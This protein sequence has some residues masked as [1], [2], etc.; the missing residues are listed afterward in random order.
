M[1]D[2]LDAKGI[3]IFRAEP[4]TDEFGMAT[5]DLPISAEPNLGV[6]KITATTEKTKAELDVRVEEY[7]LPKYEVKVNLPKEWF[8]VD[9][10][11]M[12]SIT[13]EYS[14][15]RPVAGELEIK[16]LRYVGEWQ[17][18]ASLT[19]SI[20]GDVDFELPA[21]GYIAGTPS[22]GGLGNVQ[23]DIR[24]IEKST[25][26]QE[27][28]SRLLTIAATPVNIQIIPEGTT[29][30]PGLPFNILIVTETPDN[31]LI[32]AD[33]KATVSFL[34]KEFKEVGRSERNVKTAKGKAVIEVTPPLDSIALVIEVATSDASASKVLEA[35]YSPSGNFIHVEQISEGTPLIGDIVQFRVNSTR[36]AANFY[37]EVVSRGT[38]V[39]SNFTRSHDIS[40][41]TTPMMAPFSRLLVYQILPN[42][43]VAADYIPFEVSAEYPN[44]VE[45]G[46]NTAE[47]RP[48]EEVQIDVQSEGLSRVGIAAV[49]KSVFILAENRLNLQQVFDELE[50]LYMKPQAELH[51]VSI[52]TGI[53]TR[54]L[55]MPLLMLA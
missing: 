40:I 41:K 30:K 31:K 53:T 11:L 52:Y 42:S 2:V 50:R 5:I 4:V 54:G 43:E 35:S 22:A 46:F 51:E 29:F 49:D 18:Y 24:V 25:G 27:K 47:A 20:D 36:E 28:T 13:A 6:W 48:G 7:V 12:G 9:E 39:F 16:A 8:L 44:N 15:G 45:V 26:Y 1:L 19:K 32:E 34:D 14:F 10:A 37:Y 17:E 3:K 55:W 21:V 23:L 33:V 38:V